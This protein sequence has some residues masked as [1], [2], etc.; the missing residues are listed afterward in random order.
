MTDHERLSPA[1]NRDRILWIAW[2]VVNLA[3]FIAALVLPLI[4]LRQLFVF[5]NEIVLIQVP[6]VLL[7]NGEALLAVIVFVFGILLPFVKAALYCVAAAS[8]RMVD[9]LGRFAP[10]SFFDVFMIALL[11]FVAKGT[12]GTD[13]S[14]AIGIYPLLF[15]AL[16][17]KAIDLVMRPKLVAALTEANVRP[18]SD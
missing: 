5:R 9:W 10:L 12:I 13:A 14:T 8:P 11:I 15:F 1:R 7:R 18:G 4:E 17:A 16:S 3:A 6:L 2:S